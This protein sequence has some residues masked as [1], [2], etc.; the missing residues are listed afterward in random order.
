MHHL[1]APTSLLEFLSK[2]SSSNDYQKNLII[3]CGQLGDFDSVEYAQ[4]L[5]PALD[6]LRQADIN[7]LLI[8]IGDC[9]GA[10]RFCVYTG[11]PRD[12]VVVEPNNKLHRDC[13]LYEGLKTGLD[14]W[15]NLFLMCAGIGSPGT[16]KEVLRG[17][18]GDRSAQSRIHN[19]LFNLIGGDEFLRP[20]ELATVRLQN[21]IE[22]ISHWNIYVPNHQWLCQ[23]GATFF[24][25]SENDV[26]YSYFEIGILGFSETM[27]EPLSFL[28]NYM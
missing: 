26:I 24:L 3:I 8:G 25:N 2:H 18:I 1:L 15:F 14:P 6:R 19:S 10:D 27:A 5:V 13:G 23:R 4:A 11:F 21:M 22:V 20:F 9:L 16:L 7:V 28:N 17:Y 12:Q